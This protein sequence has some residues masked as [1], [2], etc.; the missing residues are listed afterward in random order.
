MFRATT[1]V[2][3]LAFA[4]LVLGLHASGSSPAGDGGPTQGAD[5]RQKIERELRELRGRL[6]ALR[7]EAD[8]RP[9]DRPDRLADAEAFAKGITW[10]LKY[11]ATFTPADRKLLDRAR[12]RLR[13]RV[14]ALEASEVPWVGRKGK[15]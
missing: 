10:A 3:A 4:W 7:G 8:R 1:R 12:E 11:D 13:G 5:E 2:L 6:E 9:G 15:V 14:A